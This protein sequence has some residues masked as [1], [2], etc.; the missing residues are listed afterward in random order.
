MRNHETISGNKAP[1]ISDLGPPRKAIFL[2]GGVVQQ[3]P[4]VRESLFSPKK[5]GQRKW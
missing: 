4:V 1:E 5:K 2:F 3:I